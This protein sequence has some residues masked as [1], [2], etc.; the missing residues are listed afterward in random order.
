MARDGDVSAV[1][2]LLLTMPAYA[3]AIA[4]TFARSLSRDRS[5][6]LRSGAASWSVSLRWD[7]IRVAAVGR[8]GPPTEP[9]GKLGARRLD[10]SHPFPP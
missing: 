10:P 5:A 7:L 4:G 8:F 1:S 3:F 6:S 9:F 2:R